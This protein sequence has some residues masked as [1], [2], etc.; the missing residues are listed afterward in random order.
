MVNSQLQTRTP[1]LNIRT[2]GV[3]LVTL[4]SRQAQATDLLVAPCGGGNVHPTITSALQAAN[5][6]DRILI[7]P[8]TYPGDHII[9]KSVTLLSNSPTERFVIDG[10]LHVGLPAGPHT[11]VLC[12]MWLTGDLDDWFQDHAASGSLRVV[13][14]VVEGRVICVNPEDLHYTLQR[15]S[16]LST[17]HLRNAAII[18]CHLTGTHSQ[19]DLGTLFQMFGGATGAG[20]LRMIGNVIGAA[21]ANAAAR[22]HVDPRVPFEIRNNLFLAPQGTL[23][24]P[25]VYVGTT[26]PMTNV[27]RVFENNTAY[28]TGGG[29]PVLLYVKDHPSQLIMSVR[30]NHIVG[31]WQAFDI[32]PSEVVPE[33]NVVTTSTSS[34]DPLTGQPT[35]GSTALNAGDPDASFLDLDLSR[36]DAGCYG[37]SY[38]R[39]NYD[40]PMPSSAVV[41]FMDVPRRTQTGQTLFIKADGFDR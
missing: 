15:D 27:T 22:I 32:E 9:T 40:D 36:N 38:S 1:M 35:P 24:G 14:C 23:T 20:S 11:V 29:A 3:L 26:S 5:P 4:L 7:E 16:I 41:L 33:Y 30:N 37:G 39:D 8:A 12:S 21:S 17:V 18:G 34:L 25:L 31:N 13:D 10:A 19:S 28:R 6:G 2:Y